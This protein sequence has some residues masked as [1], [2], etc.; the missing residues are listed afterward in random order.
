M[1]STPE[2]LLQLRKTVNVYRAAADGHCTPVLDSLMK[3]QKNL[4]EKNALQ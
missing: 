4:Q 3:E 1:L 2:H